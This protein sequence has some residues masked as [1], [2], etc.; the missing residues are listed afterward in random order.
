M[1]FCDIKEFSPSCHA[2]RYYILIYLRCVQRILVQVHGP[3]TH[4]IFFRN[5]KKR[6]PRGQICKNFEN[7]ELGTDVIWV[8]GIQKSI[9]VLF[10]KVHQR[11]PQPRKHRKMCVGVIFITELQRCSKFGESQN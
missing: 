10:D 11:K 7:G 1:H 5:H 8:S 2:S 3:R 6:V 9:W 4:I